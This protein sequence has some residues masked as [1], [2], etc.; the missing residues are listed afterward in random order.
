M[1]SNNPFPSPPNFCNKLTKPQ[2]AEI[3]SDTKSAQAAEIQKY[4]SAEIQNCVSSRNTRYLTLF[5]SRKT[6]SYNLHWIEVLIALCQRGNLLYN[7][8]SLQAAP[9]SQ[10][11]GRLQIE[12]AQNTNKSTQLLDHW[13]HTKTQNN[14]SDHQACK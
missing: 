8:N 4:K 2:H 14:H 7:L 12:C 9:A 10:P 13:K 11:T 6:T 1:F 3:F 5:Q